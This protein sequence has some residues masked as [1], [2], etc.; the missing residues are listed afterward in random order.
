MLICGQEFKFSALNADDLDR[1]EL[2]QQHL[3]EASAVEAQRPK[4]KMGDFVRGQCRLVM[5]YL[6]ELL[7][8]GASQRLGL[9]GSDFGACQAVVTEIKEAI[10][11]EQAQ[12]PKA[13]PQN[14]E[15]RR[16]QKGKKHQHAVAFQPAP[17]AAKMV[18]RVDKQVRRQQLLRELAELDNG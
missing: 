8:A 18:A 12:L 13:A 7:G 10:T 6:D 16:A 14:R 11:A 2:A 9:T 1:M 17:A 5:D 4:N 3:T 15:Q